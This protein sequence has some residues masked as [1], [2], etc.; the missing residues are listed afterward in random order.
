MNIYHPRSNAP[1][2]SLHT[3]PVPPFPILKHPS[4]LAL[5]AAQIYRRLGCREREPRRGAG[6][7]ALEAEKRTEH[8]LVTIP[9]EQFAQVELDHLASCR[10]PCPVELQRPVCWDRDTWSMHAPRAG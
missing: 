4:I 10:Y 2:P 1:P 6:P 5:A 8:A 3:S 7:E 9:P